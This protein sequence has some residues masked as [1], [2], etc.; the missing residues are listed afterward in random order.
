MLRCGEQIWIEIALFGLRQIQTNSTIIK[1]DT[2]I[3]EMMVQYFVFQERTP[4][5]ISMLS[6]FFFLLLLGDRLSVKSER[7]FV[8][9][10]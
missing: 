5:T 4:T 6:Y 10:Y 3:Q 2:V 1:V 9:C 7:L 8:P